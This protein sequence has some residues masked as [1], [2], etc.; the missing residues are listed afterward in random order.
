MGRVEAPR[1]C[2]DVATAAKTDAVAKPYGRLATMA[3]GL[4]ERLRG[5]ARRGDCAEEGARWHLISTYVKLRSAFIVGLLLCVGRK[6][7]AIYEA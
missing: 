1:R 2:V 7:L 5:G 6:A 4:R 3:A